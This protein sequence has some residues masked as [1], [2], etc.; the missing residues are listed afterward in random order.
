[1]ALESTAAFCSD[2]IG[3]SGG[4]YVNLLGVE[5]QRS[6]V[7]SV[8]YLGYSAS[9]ESFIFEG[10]HFPAKPED[11]VFAK[12]FSA[13]AERLWMEGKWKSHPVR[14]G[15]GGLIGVLDGMKQMK[16]GKVSGEK[17]VYLVDDTEWPAV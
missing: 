1:M 12:S 7:R 2:A 16:E 3:S 14:V 9:G 5:S 11:F 8:F 15:S 17:L 4:L 13:V 6:D 10:Q